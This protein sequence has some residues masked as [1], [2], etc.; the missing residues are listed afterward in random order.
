MCWK[1]SFRSV[2]VCVLGMAV[3]AG[4][5]LASGAEPGPLDPR[6]EVH[7]PIGIANSLDTLKTFV[8]AEGN[9]SPGVGSY[10]IY[11]WVFDKATGKLFAPTM[12]DVECEHGLAEGRYLIP[13]AKWSAGAWA[14]SS[15]GAIT[16]TTELCE[17]KR[18]SRE[19]NLFVVGSRVALENGGDE[20]RAIGLYVA[21]R[22]LGPAGFDV[23]ELAVSKEGDALLVE[24]HAAIVAMAKPSEA[25]V[26]ATDTIGDLAL[27][28]RMP[29]STHATSE[30]GDC[31]GALRFDLRLSAGERRTLGFVCPV[32]PGR[33]A[34]GHQWDGVSAWA[35]FDLAALNPD[36]GGVLQP[37]P[38][39]EYYR[40]LRVSEL[41]A[42]AEEYW[43]QLVEQVR[44]DLPDERWEGAF[45]AIIAHVAME[46]NDGAPDVAV[47]NYNVFN[48]DGV[49]VANIFQ[50][51]GNTAL[52]AE[53][54]DYFAEHP[55]NG[56][57]FPE[58]DNPGQILWAMGQQWRFTRD[59]TWLRRI[60]PSAR[61]IAAMIEYCRTTEG[62]HWVRMDG[63]DF[64]P[65]LP[66][67]KRR[68]LVPGK[69]D[70]HHPE[71]TEA[72][73]IA[74]LYAARTL[75]EAMGE[76]GDA[77][78]WRTLAHRLLEDYDAK[79][80]GNLGNGYGS[81]SVLWPCRLYPLDSGKAHEQFKSKGAQRPSG[82][83]YF[84]LARAHQGL[85]AGN[86]QAGY[87]TLQRHLDHEQMRGWYAFDE[88]GN[89]MRAARAA[90]AAGVVCALPGIAM[91][92]CLTAGPLPNSGCLCATAWSLRMT[93]DWC[94]SRACPRHGLATRK[95]SS[96]RTCR[97]ISAS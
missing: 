92:Q 61:K 38:G 16:V 49:Y 52:A 54:I 57:S 11:F 29:Q 39:L 74:G 94:C 89:S 96:S 56:R 21:L 70:G 75:A 95:A 5:S 73:D 36:S 53:A 32:L 44:L 87:G 20:G 82:W 78:K 72:F 37:D 31:S 60:Y 27:Q 63:L 47:V 14:T 42:E 30:S 13:W 81:Y 93:S 12:D 19:G 71:Y 3:P 7:I 46:M 9:F 15:A 77:A 90:Q 51:S 17:V 66:E 86:R 91:S 50:K 26:L 69:C 2:V 55:F 43:R 84:P 18:S 28:G 33:R 58:A 64:G 88:G 80:G 65:A 6:G 68:E 10:G 4:V 24:D 85:L 97:R 76:S 40:G 25:G 62:P 48:R 79:F 41:F 67:G 22:P 1:R 23:R 59:K 35:Q 83:R 45:A 8:E 34:V